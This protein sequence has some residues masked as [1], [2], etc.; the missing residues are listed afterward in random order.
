[1]RRYRRRPALSMRVCSKVSLA[2]GLE[3][4][5]GGLLRDHV[6][7]T[8]DEEARSAGEDGCIDDAKAL[9]A[10][11]AEVTGQDSVVFAR[12]YSAGRRGMVAPG[13][14]SNEGLQAFVRVDIIAGQ[15]FFFDEF[16]V[17]EVLGDLADEAY[18]FHD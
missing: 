16:V 9:R 12:A 17:F 5:I 8:G 18:A 6:N 3:D 7:R 4:Y 10:M 1:M 11:N 2:C 14:V 13:I 15:L